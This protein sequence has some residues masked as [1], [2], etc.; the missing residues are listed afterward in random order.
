MI[1]HFCG[2]YIWRKLAVFGGTLSLISLSVLVSNKLTAFWADK[3]WG[4]LAE[5]FIIH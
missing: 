1:L 3:L 4:G 2:F 5:N